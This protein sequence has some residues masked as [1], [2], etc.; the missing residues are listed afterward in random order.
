M[1]RYYFHLDEDADD[2]GLDLADDTVAHREAIEAFAM[3]IREGTVS[4]DSEMR[5]IDGTGR[6]VV[7]LR[8]STKR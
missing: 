4:V 3:M 2:G 6:H 7:S 5:V 1:P 8:F